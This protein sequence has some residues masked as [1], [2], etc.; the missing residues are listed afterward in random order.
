[1]VPETLRVLFL[2][3]VVLGWRKNLSFVLG[4]FKLAVELLTRFH[5]GSLQPVSSAMSF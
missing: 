5:W 1:M 3:Y 2:K 4:G